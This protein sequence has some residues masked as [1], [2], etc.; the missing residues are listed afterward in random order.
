M[1]QPPGLAPRLRQRLKETHG[2]TDEQLDLYLAN[3]PK[4][5]RVLQNFARKYREYKMI[6]EV[7]QSR[8]CALHLKEGE[9]FVLTSDGLLLADESTAPLCLWALAPLVPFN[10]MVYDRLIEGQDPTE[11]GLDRVRCL[12]V[13][14]ECG[15]WGEVLLKVY[16]TRA[17]WSPSAVANRRYVAQ[18][19]EPQA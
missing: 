8:G 10:Y 13:G 14:L 16:C 2:Y 3:N 5:L 18:P 19:R 6:A 15:G 1:T 17:P 11:L 12:D 7:V 4:A 9:K